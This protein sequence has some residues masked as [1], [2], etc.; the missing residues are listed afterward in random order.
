[1]TETEWNEAMPIVTRQM[2]DFIRE[3]RTPLV[4]HKI[5]EEG[6]YGELLGSGAFVDLLGQIY[7]LTNEHNARKREKG[8]ILGFSLLEDDR[9]VQ[10]IGNHL[11]DPHPK[12]LAVLPVSLAAWSVSE[13]KS[14]AIVDHQ[15][16][17]TFAGFRRVISIYR[18]FNG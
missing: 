2:R 13:N 7:I 12:D 17:P 11:S 18:F 10:V 8:A 5:E 6:D 4:E 1:M 14:K 9:I 3:Y 15:L 16:N